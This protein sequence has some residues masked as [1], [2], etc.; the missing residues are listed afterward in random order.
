M[1]KYE[2]F[3]TNSQPHIKTVLF[4][5]I[6]GRFKVRLSNAPPTIKR[7]GVITARGC[8]SA[9]GTGAM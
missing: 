3:D 2:S 8:F 5:H 9:S 1:S 6:L 4:D 7:G